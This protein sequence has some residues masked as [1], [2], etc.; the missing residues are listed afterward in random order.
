MTFRQSPLRRLF[1]PLSSRQTGETEPSSW[2]RLETI[3]QAFGLLQREFVLRRLSPA[4]VNAIS[5]LVL[6]IFTL[7]FLTSIGASLYTKSTM[8]GP[9][10]GADFAGYYVAGIVYDVG[11]GERIY[12][13][14]LHRLIYQQAIPGVKNGSAPV[15]T[16][17]PFLVIPF[18][19][20]ARLPYTVAYFIWLAFSLAL[21]VG[22][23]HLLC[24]SLQAL[25]EDMLGNSLKLALSFM[26]FI[27]ECLAGGQIAAIGFFSLCSAIAFERRN[28]PVLSGLF[29]SLCWSKPQLLVFLLPMLFITRRNKAIDGFAIGSI[30]LG[31]ISLLTVGLKGGLAYGRELLSAFKAV[32]HPNVELKGWKYVDFYSTTELVTGQLGWISLVLVS[33]LIFLAVVLMT[34]YFARA[35]Q[36]S[37]NYQSIV[38]SLTITW[39]LILNCYIGI[40]D[41]ILLVVSALLTAHIFYSRARQSESPLPVRFKFI[42]FLLYVIPWTTQSVARISGVQLFT[43]GI[44]LL[45]IYQAVLFW[46]MRPAAHLENL[47]DRENAPLAVPL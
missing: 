25:P 36:K 2:S 28:R 30:V 29:L 23:F 44:I 13:P 39:T 31:T 46:H 32:I 19:L 27:I 11:S 21:Y 5:Q 10:L 16:A 34:R 6:S 22:G 14:D 47:Q 42:L 20:L 15:F 1:G 37:R 35:D 17:P 43:L 18:A 41:T 24:R 7:F 4:N 8:F 3:A 26:P 33:L 38:W 12:N 45:G 9:N 40:S